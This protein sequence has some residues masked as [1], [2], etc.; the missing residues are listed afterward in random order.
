VTDMWMCIYMD[1][2]YIHICSTKTM[3]RESGSTPVS[4]ECSR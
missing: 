3:K 4:A 1:M 2:L